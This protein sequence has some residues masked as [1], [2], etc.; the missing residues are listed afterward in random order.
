MRQKTVGCGRVCRPGRGFHDDPQK[1]GRPV[2]TAPWL[3]QLGGVPELRPVPRPTRR[4]GGQDDRGIPTAH[5]GQWS[6]VQV[7]RVINRA[8][9]PRA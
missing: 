2:P 9:V 4:T 7:Q 5:G 6:A 1:A 3:A 8:V